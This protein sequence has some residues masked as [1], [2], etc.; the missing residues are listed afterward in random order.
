VDVRLDDIDHRII[1]CLLDNARASYADIGEVVG[2]SAPAVK[3]RVDR[4][5]KDE[6]IKGY[7]ALVDPAAMGW[8]TEAF[9]EVYCSGRTSPETIRRSLLRHPEVVEAYTV[10]GEADA[11]AHLLALDTQHLENAL[12]RIRDEP[13]VLQTKS[14]LVLS[15]LIDRAPA[16]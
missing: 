10:T 13:T 14:V 16:R 6:V 9:V 15:R 2:L 12:E 7:S 11:L 5:R 4:L 3:R 1:G 8:A